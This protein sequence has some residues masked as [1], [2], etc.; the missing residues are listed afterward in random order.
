M[1]NKR[2]L[3]PRHI[4]KEIHVWRFITLK[5]ALLLGSGGGIGWLIYYFFLPSNVD[6]QIKVF[7]VVLPAA[8]MGLLVFVKPIKVRKNVR[9]FHFIKWKV[10]YN[11]RQKTF[12]Y[13]KKQF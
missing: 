9:L 8:L 2:F 11:K 12:F 7:V 3:I 1:E 13:K 6:I 5:E 4:S 10:D